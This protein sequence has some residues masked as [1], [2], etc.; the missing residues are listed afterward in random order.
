MESEEERL[1]TAR[2]LR[3]LL[4]EQLSDIES[5]RLDVQHR[6]E[7]VFWNYG[8]LQSKIS[9]IGGVERTETV[10]LKLSPV[11]DCDSHT[12][13]P[14]SL[15]IAADIHDRIKKYLEEHGER[16]EMSNDI[17]CLR[18]EILERPQ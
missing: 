9:I 4:E 14:S 12:H 2:K 6:G 15:R 10:M 16:Y 1:Q 18:R 3:N 7:S 13:L 8:G 17:Y 11:I 5:V